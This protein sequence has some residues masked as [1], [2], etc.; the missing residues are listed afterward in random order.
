MAAEVEEVRTSAPF[1]P[2]FFHAN[3]RAL[4]SRRLLLRYLM[5]V[6]RRS[7][8]TGGALLALAGAVSTKS[9]AAQGPRAVAPAKALKKSVQKH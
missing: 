8:L 4:P 1:Q 2:K 7:V 6:D 3:Q 5:P 9:E